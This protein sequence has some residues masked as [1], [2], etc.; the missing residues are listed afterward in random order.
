MSRVYPKDNPFPYQGTLSIEGTG[1]SSEQE[2]PSGRAPTLTLDPVKRALRLTGDYL[3]RFSVSEKKKG[4]FI[5]FRGDH[6]SGKTHTIYHLMDRVK[7]GA[8]RAGEGIPAPLQL[9]AKAEGPQF[10]DIYGRL[11]KQVSFDDL[12]ELS[13]RFLGVMT[14][15]QLGTELKDEAKGKEAAEKLRLNPDAVEELYRQVAVEKGA[16]E[17]RQAETV[18]QVAGRASS[19][20][21]RIMTFLPGTGELARCAYEWLTGRTLAPDDIKKLGVSGPISS[22]EV[23]KWAVQLLAVLFRRAGRP[24]I[25]YLDQY[26]KL[27]LGQDHELAAQNIGR[28]HSLVEVIPRENGMLVLSGNEDAWAALPPDFRQRFA[29]NVVPFPIL[30]LEEAKQVVCLY[31][32]PPGEHLPWEDPP[33]PPRDEKNSPAPVSTDQASSPEAGGITLLR[34]LQLRRPVSEEDLFPFTSEAVE[35]ALQFGSGNIRRFLQICAAVLDKALPKQQTIGPDTVNQVLQESRRLYTAETVAQEIE[36]ILRRRTLPFQRDFK[37]EGTT[38]DFAVLPGGW[39][40]SKEPRLLVRISQALFSQDEANQALG[41]VNVIEKLHER[42][43]PTRFVLVVLGYASPAVTKMLTPFVHDLVVYQAD[44]FHTGF[45]KALDRMPRVESAAAQSRKERELIQQQLTDLRKSLQEVLDTRKAETSA[46][47]KRLEELLQRQEAQRASER[48]PEVRGTWTEERR[49]IEEQIRAARLD[50][51]KRALEELE[52]LRAKAERDRVQA[53]RLRAVAAAGIGLAAALAG[54]I[55]LFYMSHSLWF[56][57][58]PLT[59]LLV[60]T[61]AAG[62][63]LLRGYL[64]DRSRRELASAVVSRE[65]LDRLAHAYLAAKGSGAVARDTSLLRHPNPQLRYVAA[66]AVGLGPSQDLNRLILALRSERSSIVRQMLARQIGYLIGAKNVASIDFPTEMKECGYI[67]EE[68]L[69]SRPSF[70]SAFR[71]TDTSGL[72]EFLLG[73]PRWLQTLAVIVGGPVVAGGTSL[74]MDVAAWVGWTPHGYEPP[75]P[76]GQ[77]TYSDV[78]SKL[79]QAFQSGLAVNVFPLENAVRDA[80]AELSPFEEWGLGTLD[81]LRHINDIDQFYLFFRQVQFRFAQTFPGGVG[82]A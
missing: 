5:V 13:R 63:V 64:H 67:V 70:S 55:S 42:D 26:E 80:V 72:T 23:G 53:V 12:R 6:G 19:D 34:R 24:L 43:T 47:E 14:G 82:A 18:D 9:Y 21:R 62:W 71:P 39:G 74:A 68:C 76:P 4:Q 75:G 65:D 77:S 44:K 38:L 33:V 69:V 17:E 3:E 66:K 2:D 11:V 48:Q 56:W 61:A 31:L 59:F 50:R 1:A 57:V 45:E 10:L 20:F 41:H 30:T 73:S 28:L 52:R 29:D 78:V 60:A 54:R 27:V 7:S 8:L 35:S 36:E 32:T 58:L 25:I 49:R 81:D 46:L 37:F 16:V 40:S 22:P 79:G 51:Q 15:E